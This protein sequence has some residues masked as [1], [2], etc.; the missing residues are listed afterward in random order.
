MSEKYKS[1]YTGA[2]IDALLDKIKEYE[3]ATIKIG[4]VKSARDDSDVSVENVGTDTDVVLNFV[5]PRG[6]QGEQ[7]VKGDDGNILFA[8]F[9]FDDNGNLIVTT[10]DGY[11]GPTFSINKNGEMEVIIY[12]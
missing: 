5:L 7:G 6:Y 4:A 1:K 8:A 11:N 10:P 12:E 9:S 2:Q 3:G